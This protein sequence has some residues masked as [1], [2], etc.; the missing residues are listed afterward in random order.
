MCF[1]ADQQD[2]L[3]PFAV[4]GGLISYYNGDTTG[5]AYW[6]KAV[7]AA[8]AAALAR[9]EAAERLAVW[10]VRHGA[11]IDCE[12]PD[13]QAVFAFWPDERFEGEPD[14]DLCENTDADL[15]R[16]LKQASGVE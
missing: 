6:A 13:V 16:A 7:D 1:K 8:L 11:F 15:L 4:A 14:M 2:K 5:M 9:A 12:I 3:E 10:A